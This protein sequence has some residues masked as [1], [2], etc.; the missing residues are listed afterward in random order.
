M[1]ELPMLG[2]G[3]LA[4]ELGHPRGLERGTGLGNRV[5]VGLG[6]N[7]GKGPSDRGLVCRRLKNKRK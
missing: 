6:G 4:P 7:S 5:E 1:Q 3:S 2:K